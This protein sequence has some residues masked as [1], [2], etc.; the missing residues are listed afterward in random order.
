VDA[1]TEPYPP[2]RSSKT[3]STGDGKRAVVQ[4]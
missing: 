1:W 2:S 4:N 3:A